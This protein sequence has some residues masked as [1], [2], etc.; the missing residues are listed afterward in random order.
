MS[1]ITLAIPLLFLVAVA[2]AV[3]LLGSRE[4][5]LAT[6]AQLRHA[7]KTTLRWRGAGVLLGVVVMGASLAYRPG[8]GRGLMLAVPLLGLCVLAGVIV[9][10]VRVIAPSGPIRHAALEVRRVSAYL[11]RTLA[12]VIL[13][14]VALLVMLLAA[15]TVTASADDLGRAGRSLFQ[16]CTSVSSQTVGPWPGSYYSRP[17]LEV[18]LA[19]AVLASIALRL[20]VRRP[21]QGSDPAYDDLLRAQAAGA[22]TAACGVLVG[23][24]LAGVSL[25]CASALSRTGCHPGWWGSAA[26]ALGLLSVASF[27]LTM[28]C[29]AVLVRGSIRAV[30]RI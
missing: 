4:P 16:Q 19:G 25:V 2:S 1:I 14:A 7:A 24:P 27:A 28:R 6:S 8:L 5:V 12:A 10:E 20:V 21:R 22:V 15:T 30:P 11:P 26:A 9:G 3:L 18:V 29:G 13:G 17:L 23:L